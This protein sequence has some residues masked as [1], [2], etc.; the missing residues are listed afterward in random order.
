MA[1]HTSGFRESIETVLYDEDGTPALVNMTNLAGVFPT[2][3]WSRAQF[4][5]YEEVNAESLRER[6]LVSSKACLG[7]PIACGKLTEVRSG[8]YHGNARLNLYRHF[9]WRRNQSGCV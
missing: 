3:Y 6:I 2:R 9:G 1:N 8:P 5:K 4:E 7:C